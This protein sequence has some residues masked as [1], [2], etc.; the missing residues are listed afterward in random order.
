MTD[1]EIITLYFDRSEEA[2]A[3][4]QRKYDGYCR[5]ILARLLGSPRDVEETLSDTWLKAWLSIPPARP[6]DLK[7]YIAKIGRNLALNRLRERRAVRRGDG[8]DAVLEELGEV[9]GGSTAEEIV[10]ARE[11]QQAV[12]HFLR[13]LPRRDCDIFVRR[14]FYAESAEEIAAWYALRPNTVTVSLHRTRKKLREYLLK[15]GYL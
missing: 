2:I 3:A 11:L 8:S 14:C 7:L 15:E 4:T 9:L 6:E 5:S 1:E 10:N 13:T 12:N